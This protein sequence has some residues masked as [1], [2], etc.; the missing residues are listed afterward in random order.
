M[1][2]LVKK[3]FLKKNNEINQLIIIAFKTSLKN[4][5]ENFQQDFDI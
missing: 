4:Y 3:Q 1:N 2:H 5:Y